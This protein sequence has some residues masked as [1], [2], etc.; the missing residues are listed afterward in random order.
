MPHN[1]QVLSVFDQIQQR[2]PLTS[3]ARARSQEELFTRARQVE[4]KYAVA[5]RKIA[6]HCGDIIRGFAPADPAVLPPLNAMLNRYADILTPWANSMANYMLR[7]VNHWDERAWRI[8]SKNLSLAVRQE[9]DRTDVGVV[10]RRLQQEQVDLI[11]SIPLT[12]AQR[13]HKLT[14]EAMI[15]GERAASIIQEIVRS[16]HVA[17]SH[18]SLIAI[19]EVGRATTSFTQARATHLGSTHYRWRTAKDRRVR[20]EHQRLEGKVCAWDDPPIA[21]AKGERAHPGSIYRC[22]CWP[23]VIFD[24]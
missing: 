19:T 5:L 18:A 13:V 10:F 11:R 16:G 6:R 2:R 20:A 17:Q 21:G 9:V 3:D 23:E 1:C 8:H 15:G 24:T 7:E 14:E 4:R 12:A 22:R